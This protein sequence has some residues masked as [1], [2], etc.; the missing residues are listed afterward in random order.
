MKPWVKVS[1]CPVGK[2]R[3]TSRYPSRGWNAFFTVYQDPQGWMGEGIMDQIYPMMYFQGN[4]FY[5]FALDWKE[6]DGKRWIIPGLGIY[7]LSPREQDWPLDEIVRQIHFTRQ[8]KLNGQAYFRNRFLLDN[9]KGVLDELEENFYTY[10][11]LIPPM[12]WSD[13]I[14]PSVPSHPSVQQIA[15]G[16]LRMSWQASAD[17]SNQSVVYH[18]YG[19]DTYPVDIK[20]PQ[21]L[22]AT[23]LIANEYEYTAKLPWLQKRYFAVTAAD[24]FGNESAP[25]TLNTVSDM[26]IPLLNK[27]NMLYLPEIKDA[28]TIIIYNMTNE[29]I[30]KTGYVHKL[31][32]VSLPNGFYTVKIFNRQGKSLFAGSIMK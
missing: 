29:E 12:T 11:A 3:D 18:L 25:L 4:N 27:G 30:W 5:P 14:P 24:R 28:Q 9:T 13:S 8:I 21:N 26:D 32:L 31:S 10:P 15:N 1:T 19:S 6:N 23:H 16:K 17:N 22:I 7:F 2:Y 20:Q